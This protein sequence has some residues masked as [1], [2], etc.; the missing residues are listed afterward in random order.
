MKA[1]SPD[2]SGHKNGGSNLETHGYGPRMGGGGGGVGT[3]KNKG[4]HKPRGV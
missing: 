2:E 1:N 3:Q 4:P